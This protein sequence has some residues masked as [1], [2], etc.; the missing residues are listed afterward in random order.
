MSD[1]VPEMKPLGPQLEAAARALNAAKLQTPAWL[2][3]L[4]KVLERMEQYPLTRSDRFARVE[5]TDLRRL[6]GPTPAKAPDH[7]ARALPGGVRERLRSQ[8]GPAADRL[9]V[10]NDEGADRLAHKHGADAVSKGADVYFARG[11]YRPHDAIG[12]ALLAHEAV[13][14]EHAM[15]PSAPWQRTGAAEL[16]AEEVQAHAVERAMRGG[17]PAESPAHTPPRIATPPAATLAAAPAAPVSGAPASQ[18]PMAAAADRSF[19]TGNSS[20]AMDME[21]LRQ[22][23]MRDLMSQIRADMERGG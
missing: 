2:A 18:R 20:S 13:H 9:R 17:R 10:H 1:F 3:P 5:A 21:A 4:T 8:V 12:F 11:R 22:T 6:D 7:E 23:L 16:A 19:D 14:V 15:R